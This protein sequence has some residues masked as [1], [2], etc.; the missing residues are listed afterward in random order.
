[1]EV[2]V[3]VSSLGRS[4]R[5]VQVEKRCELVVNGVQEDFAS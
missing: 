3:T 1:M 4:K 2:R 5:V